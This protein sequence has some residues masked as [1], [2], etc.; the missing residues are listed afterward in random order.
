MHFDGRDTTGASGMVTRCHLHRGRSRCFEYANASSTSYQFIHDI[1]AP[2]AVMIYILTVSTIIN[3]QQQILYKRPIVISPL[4]LAVR[5]TSTSKSNSIL[6][7]KL[8]S[9]SSFFLGSS[10]ALASVGLRWLNWLPGLPL[11]GLRPE[12]NGSFATSGV[13]WVL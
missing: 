2:S 9:L 1:Y 8:E 6:I 5:C 4:I 12:G 13:F 7:F 11:R 3:F 10:P